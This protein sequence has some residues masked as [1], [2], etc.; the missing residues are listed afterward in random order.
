MGDKKQRVASGGNRSFIHS[1]KE[2]RNR[3]ADERVK[4]KIRREQASKG[5]I[6]RFFVPVGETKEFIILDDAPDCYLYEH[7]LPDPRTGKFTNHVTCPKETED[8]AACTEY[9]ESPYVLFLSVID[10]TPFKD[11]NGVKHN[12][13]RK[14]MAVKQSQQKKFDRLMSREGS[15]RGALFQTSRD[16]PKDAAIGNDMELLEWVKEKKLM[17]K[18]IRTWEDRENKEH[19]ENMGEPFVY[20]DIFEKPD[21]D[22][23]RAMLG[24]DPPMGSKKQQD[25]D[26]DKD[27]W[28]DGGDDEPWD[29]DDDSSS[30]NKRRKGRGKEKKSSSSGKRNSGGDSS[31]S[32]KAT[33]R[34]ASKK[35]RDSGGERSSRRSRRSR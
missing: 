10:L 30:S 1:G 12:A 18:F 32:R 17:S 24:V 9:G 35:D 4:S 25:R 23:I 6:F 11:K 13:S 27:S 22:S 29:K 19:V 21:A 14:L 2:G 5:R 26:L 16:G 7:T 15:L 34:E 28:G 3:A 8:C 20:A 33:G 31:S